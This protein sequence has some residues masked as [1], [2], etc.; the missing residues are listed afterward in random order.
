MN[1]NDISY[2]DCVWSPYALYLENQW[3]SCALGQIPC[4]L[5]KEKR[6]LLNK[7][8]KERFFVFRLSFPS[9][10]N[11]RKA[12]SARQKV[13]AQLHKCV[14]S[15]WRQTN[16]SSSLNSCVTTFEICE[17]MRLS[18]NDDRKDCCFHT[19]SNEAPAM[20]KPRFVCEPPGDPGS[21]IKL[22]RTIKLLVLM[23]QS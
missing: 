2:N 23:N 14:T 6:L 3:T 7:H 19:T 15:A 9:A 20:V 5:S 16:G 1:A 13:V 4:Q 11:G 17:H 21:Q 22:R 18:I 8:R 12:S 10:L